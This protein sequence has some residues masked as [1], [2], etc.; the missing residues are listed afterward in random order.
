MSGFIRR[1]L[2]E[3]IS[4]E[5]VLGMGLWSV[6]GDISQLENALL[7]LAINARDAMPNGGKLTIETANVYLDEHAEVTPGQ[8]VMFAVSDSGVGM[9]QET[10]DKA[11]EPFFT[12]KEPGHG[13][14]LGLP[15]VYCFVK[16]SNGHIT[17]YSEIGQ[18]TT[19]KLYL[20]QLADDSIERHEAGV[21]I[22]GRDPGTSSA[23]GLSS[24]S[25]TCTRNAI[26]HQGGLD[27]GVELIV[28]PFTYA[29]LVAKIRRVLE[30]EGEDA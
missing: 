10:I 9:T 6:S 14:G 21:V 12:T 20:P 18:D 8:Y 24:A 5:I 28:K 16:Q 13:T 2:G 23:V 22:L 17:I 26:I 29:A 30:K 3:N 19:V 4:V 15:Q 27:P 11:F 7:N 1:T 25:S